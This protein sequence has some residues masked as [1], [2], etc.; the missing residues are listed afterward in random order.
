MKNEIDVFYILAKTYLPM[1]DVMKLPRINKAFRDNYIFD[2]HKNAGIWS[3]RLVM[4]SKKGIPIVQAEKNVSIVPEG[5]I[6]I[7]IARAVNRRLAEILENA[8]DR[9]QVIKLLFLQDK[10]SINKPWQRN[11]L[12]KFLHTVID[13]ADNPKIENSIIVTPLSFFASFD[14]NHQFLSLIDLIESVYVQNQRVDSIGEYD[15]ILENISISFYIG[16]LNENIEIM[17]RI[18]QLFECMFSPLLLDSMIRDDYLPLRPALLEV[19]DKGSQPLVRQL[20]EMER[21]IISNNI[22]IGSYILRSGVNKISPFLLAADKN[23]INVLETLFSFTNPNVLLL[24]REDLLWALTRAIDQ[25]YIDVVTYISNE[26]KNNHLFS[27]NDLHDIYIK[28][29]REEDKITPKLQKS[30]MMLAFNRYVLKERIIETK[31]E[32]ERQRFYTKI[33]KY[34]LNIATFLL[35]VLF[36]CVAVPGSILFVICK[37]LLSMYRD[38]RQMVAMVVSG[39]KSAINSLRQCWSSF[40][41]LNPLQCFNISGSTSKIHKVTGVVEAS[42]LLAI[43]KTQDKSGALNDAAPKKRRSGYLSHSLY[44]NSQIVPI[45][46]QCGKNRSMKRAGLSVANKYL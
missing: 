30:I 44:R 27:D 12:T 13:Y 43:D 46:R 36:A 2:I 41:N 9:E 14:L 22:G 42:S 32:M 21:Q 28:K 16:A 38:F 4:L 29:L 3:S 5:R 24:I 18:R 39:Y 37:S 11:D 31:K 1:V 33:K 19:I 40:V 35:T 23:D 20:L 26:I 45:G 7:D 17:N 6:D 15:E 8:K 34:L 25:N 10:Y